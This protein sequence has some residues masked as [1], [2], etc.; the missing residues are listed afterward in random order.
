M[1]H[2]KTFENYDDELIYKPKDYIVLNSDEIDNTNKAYSFKNKTID[3]FCKIKNIV[4]RQNYPFVYEVEFYND[5]C[6]LI[7]NNE[8][9]RLMT[10]EEIEKFEMKKTTSK[11]NI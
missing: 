6:L 1:K 9:E 3:I 8:I 11:F 5:T 2:L 7:Q 10:T 4:R